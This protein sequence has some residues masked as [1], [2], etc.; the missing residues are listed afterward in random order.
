MGGN[1]LTTPIQKKKKKKKDSPT[2]NCTTK[3]M[4]VMYDFGC[5]RL[6]SA[7]KP[8]LE[9]R[10]GFIVIYYRPHTIT[11][12]LAFY[13]FFTDEHRIVHTVSDDALMIISCRYHY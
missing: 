9:P 13:G 12:T 11:A 5:E 6:K 1:D 3:L 10:S 4:M 2:K 7:Q 8:F